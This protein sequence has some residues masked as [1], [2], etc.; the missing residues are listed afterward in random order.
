MR[1]NGPLRVPY[2]IIFRHN[3]LLEAVDVVGAGPYTR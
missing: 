3:T 2:P 1:P